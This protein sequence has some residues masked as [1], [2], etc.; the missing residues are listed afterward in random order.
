[1]SLKE[2]WIKYSYVWAKAR[3]PTKDEFTSTTKICMLGLGVIG[4]IGFV[5]F[6][7]FKLATIFGGLPL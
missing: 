3:K 6:L 7:G 2:K 5:I 4:S 1:M